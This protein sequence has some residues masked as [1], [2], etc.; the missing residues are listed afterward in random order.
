MDKPNGDRPSLPLK[1]THK[2]AITSLSTAR[3]ESYDLDNSTVRLAQPHASQDY[4][5]SKIDRASISRL[6]L[7]LKRLDC[8][9][10]VEA[11]SSI[12]LAAFSESRF[13][14]NDYKSDVIVDVLRTFVS[15]TTSLLVVC[16]CIR[17]RLLLQL[18]YA[19]GEWERSDDFKTAGLSKMLFG[20]VLLVLVHCP[21]RLDATFQISIMNYTIEYSVDSLLTFFV[22]MRFYLVLRVLYHYS[23]YTSERAEWVLKAHGLDITTHFAIKSYIQS[24]PMLSVTIVFILA[25]VFWA[26]LLL[27]TEKPDRVEE[28]M[29]LNEGRQTVTVDSNLDTFA[30]CFWLTFVTTATVGYGDVY[31]YTHFGRTIAMLACIL[32]NVYTGLLVLA[33]QNN[34]DMTEDQSK[35]IKYS[36][37]R[38]NSSKLNYSASQ[39]IRQFI[40]LKKLHKSFKQKYHKAWLLTSYRINS[41]VEKFKRSS[42]LPLAKVYGK[43]N[44]EARDIKI[45]GQSDYLQK[46][47][48]VTKLKRHLTNIKACR[49]FATKPGSAAQIMEMMS[50]CWD[51]ELTYLS[52]TAKSTFRSHGLLQSIHKASLSLSKKS[53]KLKTLTAFICDSYMTNDCVDSSKFM[54]VLRAKS[55]LRNHTFMRRRSYFNSMVTRTNINSRLTTRNSQAEKDSST[56][57]SIASRLNQSSASSSDEDSSFESS[58]NS[59]VLDQ[60]LS[61]LGALSVDKLRKL[62]LDES[63][64]RFSTE[65]HH[66]RLSSESGLFEKVIV[67]HPQSEGP[68]SLEWSLQGN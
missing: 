25:S 56:T 35:A 21:P 32:G 31:P 33:L 18:K 55:T 50:E 20:E 60:P 62:S 9:I 51:I 7:I 65:S 64:R 26:E 13:F 59:S 54:K 15:I 34:L 58:I 47:V 63:R 40:Q 46:K 49:R 52:R 23:E 38:L 39:T 6:K 24:R 27:L 22:L 8:A 36:F 42:L 30:N 53:D 44:Q 12:L 4:S 67:V 19:K 61:I 68:S 17:A 41:K 11:L 28:Q 48:E 16:L 43:R 37:Q 57:P 10:A 45:L 5:I 1:P 66:R 29:T 14:F 3:L 2:S